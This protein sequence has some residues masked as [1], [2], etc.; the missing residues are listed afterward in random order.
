MPAAELRREAM[1]RPSPRLSLGY[2]LQQLLGGALGV[3]YVAPKNRP[4][5]HGCIGAPATP[6]PP[7]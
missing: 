5:D 4:Q 1:Q 3:N 2:I 6:S 7:N